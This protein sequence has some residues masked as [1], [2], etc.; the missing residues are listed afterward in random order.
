MVDSV[1][2]IHR[3]QEIEKSIEDTLWKSVQDNDH[4]KALQEYKNAKKE[5][6]SIDTQTR[7]RR[8]R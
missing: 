1:D 2:I 3:I 6:E 7:G 4:E 8:S 5:L